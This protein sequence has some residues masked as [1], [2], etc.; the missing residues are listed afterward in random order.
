MANAL[1]RH[2]I[3][4]SGRFGLAWVEQ[5]WQP[6]IPMMPELEDIDLRTVEDV[7]LSD[8]AWAVEVPPEKTGHVLFHG[9]KII[10]LYWNERDHDWH[11]LN[12]RLPEFLRLLRRKG[13]LDVMLS[14]PKDGIGQIDDDRDETKGGH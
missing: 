8:P 13:R 12:D 11:Q 7:L 4:S 2:T 9:C 6:G 14:N 3:A 10:A 5:D 1:I